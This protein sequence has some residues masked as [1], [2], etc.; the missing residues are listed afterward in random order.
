MVIPRFARVAFAALSLAF[1]H[2]ALAA[3]AAVDRLFAFIDSL[4]PAAI[5]LPRDEYSELA[6][7]GDPLAPA[8]L[9]SM[10]HEAGMRTRAAARHT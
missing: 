7:A 1:A 10:R 6:F 9:N 5:V 8:L 4:I 3:R 2:A